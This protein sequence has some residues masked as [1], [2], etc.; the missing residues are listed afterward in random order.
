MVLMTS[1]LILVIQ[2]TFIFHQELSE[3]SY[4]EHYLLACITL[5]ITTALSSNGPIILRHLR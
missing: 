1:G 5:L 2:P 4:K 3:E